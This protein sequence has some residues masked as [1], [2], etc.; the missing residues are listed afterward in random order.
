MLDK[1]ILCRQL[2]ILFSVTGLQIDKE[3]KRKEESVDFRTKSTFP[4]SAN[5]QNFRDLELKIKIIWEV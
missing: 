1:I 4:K 5:F 3:K 2:N